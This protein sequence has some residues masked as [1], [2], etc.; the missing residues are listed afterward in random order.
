MGQSQSLRI[1][2]GHFYFYFIHYGSFIIL[3]G[4]SFNF[5]LKLKTFR[6]G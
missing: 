5:N 6:L 2:G 4:N 3:P 1:N